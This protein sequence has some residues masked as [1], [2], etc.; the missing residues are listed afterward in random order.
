MK[1][2]S[3]NWRGWLIC[4]HSHVETVNISKSISKKCMLGHSWSSWFTQHFHAQREWEITPN[5][6]H[7]WKHD[8]I[9]K[10]K[11]EVTA[12]RDQCPVQPDLFSYLQ[13]NRYHRNTSARTPG[14]KQQRSPGY[15]LP[16]SSDSFW[17]IRRRNATAHHLIQHLGEIKIS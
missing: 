3:K 13:N 11:G 1:F 8:D 2:K 7:W 16:H 4:N 15:P 17:Q 10:T 6:W 14:K 5:Y 12:N 9:S